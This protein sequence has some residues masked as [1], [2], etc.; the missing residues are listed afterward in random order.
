MLP[1]RGRDLRGL[2]RGF[3]ALRSVFFS[4]ACHS[5]LNQL[6]SS[7]RVKLSYWF[8]WLA[9]QT[10]VRDKEVLD[11]LHYLFIQLIECLYRV[12]V[13]GSYGDGD[14]PIIALGFAL[15]RLFS[16]NH[17]NQASGDQAANKGFFLHKQE[18][19][20][21]VTIFSQGRRDIAKIKGKNTASWQDFAQGKEAMSFI[22]LVLV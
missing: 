8:E 11:L 20:E 2:E 10:T 22:I 5:L 13:M 19:I 17:S 18:D 15:V 1:S 9:F 16:L 6:L 14:E 12:I 4:K 21:W 7:L 3:H